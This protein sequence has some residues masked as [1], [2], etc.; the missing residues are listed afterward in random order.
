[1]A[2]FIA[3]SNMLRQTVTPP[4]QPTAVP[5]L[6]TQVVVTTHDLAVGSV[7]DAEDIQLIELPV[8]FVPRD[9][10]EDLESIIGRITT[11]HMIQGEM[12]LEHHLADPTNISH[13][14]G[15][16]IGDDQ[17]LMAFPATDMMSTLNILQR[18]D[19]V[20]IYATINVR[21]IPAEVGPEATPAPV[22]RVEQEEVTRVFTF[23][24]MQRVSVS[25]VVVE[26]IRQ[27]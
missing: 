2:G 15:Y 17:V 1:M 25:A 21:V 9:A 7:L 20:D 11:V 23:D 5:V 27:E 19:I 22:A 12:V 13:D 10:S 14:I 3:I 16:V 4:P 24:A 8:A 6:T 26:I 18:G